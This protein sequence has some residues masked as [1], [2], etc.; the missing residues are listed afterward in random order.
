MKTSAIVLLAVLAT[1]AATEPRR[2]RTLEGHGGDHSISM[3]MH[4]SKAEK[5]AIEAAVE[6]DVAGPAKAAKL[7]KPKASKAGSMPD[8]ASAKSAKMSM[9]TKSGKSED[10]DLKQ[11]HYF[12][13]FQRLVSHDVSPFHSNRAAVDAKASKESHMSISGDMS[14]AKSHKAEAEAEA[15]DVTEMS[16]AKAGKDEALTEDMCMPFA[17][18]DKEMSVKSKQGKT[19]MSVADAKASKESSMP[20]SKAAKIFKGKSGKSGSLSMLKSEKASSAHSLSMPKAEKVH[21]MSA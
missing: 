20:S 4:S 15:E 9:D 13:S 7:F 8:E 19:E 14:M 21:S 18:S 10:A 16:M 6:E 17:K 3:S 1:T 2:L 11:P 12:R 5:Q